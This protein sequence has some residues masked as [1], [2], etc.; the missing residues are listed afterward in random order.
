MYQD[1]LQRVAPEL[2][3][4]LAEEYAARNTEERLRGG[5]EQE[6]LSSAI[7]YS[8]LGA[9]SKAEPEG[10]AWVERLERD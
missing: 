8:P 3:Q 6:A 7:S 5:P 4:E 9:V 2:A 1:V 10:A